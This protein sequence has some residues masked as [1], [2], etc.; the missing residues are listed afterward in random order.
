MLV[1]L[2]TDPDRWRRYQTQGE[3]ELG[4]LAAEKGLK[5]SD[6][7]DEQRR[8]FVDELAHGGRS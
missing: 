8:E 1:M 2:R 7:N 6:L 5:W 4:K 3:E